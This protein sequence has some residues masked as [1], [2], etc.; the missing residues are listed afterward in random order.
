ML[1]AAVEEPVDATP[2]QPR[3]AAAEV[4]VR[5]QGHLAAAFI[6]DGHE[7]A[8]ANGLASLVIASVEG[9][10]AMSRAL[11]DIAP[12]DQVTAQLLTAAAPPAR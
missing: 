3:A 12:F 6:A 11:Q 10:V 1:A 4:F 5:W 8:A 7:P 2:S 9:A